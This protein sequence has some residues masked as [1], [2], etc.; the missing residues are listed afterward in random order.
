MGR[1]KSM[2]RR[3][4]AREVNGEAAWAREVNGEAARGEGGRCC[5]PRCL[6]L[7]AAGERPGVT[8]LPPP[9]PPLA[10]L[11]SYCLL[12]GLLYLMLPPYWLTSLWGKMGHEPIGGHDSHKATKDRV[13]RGRSSK[14]EGTT[15]GHPNQYGGSMR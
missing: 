5:L 12:T 8:L 2:G 13:A 7:P 11:T 15:R 1:G 9:S 6:L 4:G 14:S 3:H 10:Y